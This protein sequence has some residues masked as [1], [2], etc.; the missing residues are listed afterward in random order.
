MTGTDRGRDQI[1]DVARGTLRGRW[2]LLVRAIFLLV[3][4][5]T[6][7][8]RIE[9]VERVPASGP[10]LVVCNHLHN[11]DPVLLSASFPRPLHFMAK[12]ELFKV[13]GVGWLIRRVGAFPVDRGKADRSALRRAEAALQQGI[14]VGMFPEG[15]RSVARSLRPALPGAALVAL[16]AQVPILPMVITG[17]E[18][19]PGNGAK[20]RREAGVRDPDPG[21]PG[22]RVRIGQPFHLPSPPGGGRLSS[23][24]AIELMMAEVARL[25]PP[26]YRG[27]YAEVAEQTAE[28]TSGGTRGTI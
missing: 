25:L 17:S 23:E 6:I 12:K 24:A 11:A 14:A 1:E 27:V 5:L 18:R 3:L 22:V 8:L 26:A 13:P 9:G 16:R 28:A 10:I 7:G 21:H 19:L 2:F 20:A 4:R 15:T